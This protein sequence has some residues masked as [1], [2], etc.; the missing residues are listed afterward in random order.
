MTIMMRVKI[1]IGNNS[2]PPTTINYF[3]LHHCKCRGK[4]A[5]ISTNSINYNL[6]CNK[7]FS[8]SCP[9]IDTNPSPSPWRCKILHLI[10]A[11]LQNKITGDLGQN[12]NFFSDIFKNFWRLNS[13][14]PIKLSV[15]RTILL[16]LH[17]SA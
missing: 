6:Q 11:Y 8:K 17:I 4:T 10:R 12:I 13:L 15:E 5:V 16:K 9:T 2:I 1:K 7:F 14:Q 3:S